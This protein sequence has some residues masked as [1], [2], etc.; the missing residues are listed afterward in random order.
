MGAALASEYNPSLAHEATFGNVT[1]H[2]FSG[3]G[4]N[5]QI[6][7]PDLP[8]GCALRGCSPLG[9][10]HARDFAVP[11]DPKVQLLWTR[12]GPYFEQLSEAGCS[13]SGGVAVCGPRRIGKAQNHGEHGQEK[14]KHKD[15][16]NR[17]IPGLQG[18]SSILTSLNASG[19]TQWHFDVGPN[20][21]KS[22]S[23]L[24]PITDPYGDTIW[25][26][27]RHMALVSGGGVLQWHT[28]FAP[29]IGDTGMFSAS[30]TSDFTEVLVF[31]S[32][33]GFIFTYTTEGVPVAGINLADNSTVRPKPTHFPVAMPVI[34]STKVFIL[35]RPLNSTV[36][37]ARLYCFDV[38]D[39]AVDRMRLVF[40]TDVPTDGRD[41]ESAMIIDGKGR[42]YYFSC[43]SV[44][45]FSIS[46]KHAEF[47]GRVPHAMRIGQFFADASGE[48]W[49]V[50]DRHVLVSV[51]N[52]TRYFDVGR[53]IA[54]PVVSSAGTGRGPLG[55]C[56]YGDIEGRYRLVSLDDLAIA[57][58]VN[59]TGPGS[60]FGQLAPIPSTSVLVMTSESGVH[61]IALT[62][63]K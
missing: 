43:S 30:V 46:G 49:A 19:D 60:L 63:K 31:A 53:S 5:T 39:V 48:V 24:C 34:N 42:L 20:L 6:H 28:S 29:R 13:S 18:P 21:A 10:F 37:D 22:S 36:S 27:E 57:G 1:F 11:D 55:F 7:D 52:M 54:T 2:Y 12:T 38:R 23:S 16:V 51:H 44:Y 59:V 17:G 3:A 56:H 40:Q 58:S 45:S 4:H 25:Y 15:Q 50:A 8:G 33:S 62:E 61:G 9:D 47:V 14:K 32:K 41:C 26:D 35:S